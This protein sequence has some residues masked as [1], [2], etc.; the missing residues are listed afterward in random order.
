MTKESVRNHFEGF[1]TFSKTCEY[2]PIESYTLNLNYPPNSS[3]PISTSNGY[4]LQNLIEKLKRFHEIKERCGHVELPR[5]RFD[6]AI[7]VHVT[8]L[9]SLRKWYH[10]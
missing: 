6:N 5:A 9:R 1:F 8:M 10:H 4:G 7:A 2:D 3:W